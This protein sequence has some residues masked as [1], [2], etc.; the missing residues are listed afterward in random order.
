[1][2]KEHKPLISDKCWECV[3]LTTPICKAEN[4]RRGGEDCPAYKKMDPD[5]RNFDSLRKMVK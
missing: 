3:Y 5:P 1:M 2:V 4:R